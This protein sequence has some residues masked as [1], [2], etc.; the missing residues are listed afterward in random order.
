M[1]TQF[2]LSD[3]FIKQNIANGEF[4]I[5]KESL[6]ID[7]NGYLS[8]TRHPF[9]AQPNITRDFCENQIELITDVFDSAE[10]ALLHLER[11]QTTVVQTLQQL[12]TGK[13]FLWPFS[14]PPY[15]KGEAD[16]PI[17]QFEGKYKD[18]T[19]YRNY[20]AEKYGKKK[21]L[22][23]G[24]HLN[25][26]F[27][28]KLLK[29]GYQASDFATKET[30][31]SYKDCMYLHLA[32]KVVQHCWLIVY[33]MAASPVMDA[34]FLEQEDTEVLTKYASSRCGELGYWNDFTPV[35]DY[36]NLETYIQS[37]EG[38]IG[39]GQLK[40]VAELYYPVRLKPRGENSLEALKKNGINHIEFRM[41]D[42]NPLSSIGLL[43][44]DVEFLHYFMLYLVKQENIV[45][46]EEEQIEA[47][48]NEKQAAKFD[49]TGVFIW[50]VHGNR[51][52]IRE[53]ALRIL[54]DMEGYYVSLGEPSV[55]KNI[56]YQEEKLLIPE[57]R[58]ADRI[59]R[60]YGAD[61]VKQGI[62]LAEAYTE[63]L[64][65]NCL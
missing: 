7:T 30:Y 35:F 60:K 22:Y 49:D 64:L 58:Y 28:D 16:I 36:H 62:R 4:G 25:Y 45:L 37:I 56:R 47:I 32:Q 15:V 44:E 46:T 23:S 2:G 24:I 8:H 55:V 52:P 18:K 51:T 13:E 63:E 27:S 3:D 53:A 34:S 65:G 39:G 19:K 59:Q 1:K 42:V 6:R 12:A 31:Q 11:L 9:E 20:L 38:Y 43:K 5:E 50:E 40:S 21:M 26:S 14:N 10:D 48:E 29:K 54:R 33:L 17:A 41:L 61:Y 57:N